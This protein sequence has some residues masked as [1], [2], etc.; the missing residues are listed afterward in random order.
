MNAHNLL[1]LNPVLNVRNSTE[2]RNFRLTFLQIHG[3]NHK[4]NHLKKG[5]FVTLIQNK[6][7]IFCPE[8][9]NT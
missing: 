2:T 5:G 7:L 4:K 8:Y 3:I 6:K 1:I 9:C